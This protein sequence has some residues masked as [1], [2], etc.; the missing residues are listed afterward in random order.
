MEFAGTKWNRRRNDHGSSCWVRSYW[1]V[2][3]VHPFNSYGLQTPNKSPQAK[4]G[5]GREQLAQ[6]VFLY[7]VEPRMN[8]IRQTGDSHFFIC[9]SNS[10]FASKQALTY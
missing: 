5:M 4:E 6:K 9:L 1:D 7:G 10:M 2:S 8:F 3:R